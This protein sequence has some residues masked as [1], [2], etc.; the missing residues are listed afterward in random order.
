MSNHDVVF[1]QHDDFV[2]S[3]GETLEQNS[4]QLGRATGTISAA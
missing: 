2:L 3:K 1:V 4:D